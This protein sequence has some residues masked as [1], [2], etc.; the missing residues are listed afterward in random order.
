MAIDWSTV[1]IDD[2]PRDVEFWRQQSIEDRLIAVEK[3][4]EK[5]FGPIA[6]T[7]RVERVIQVFDLD[8]LNGHW[9]E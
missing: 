4:R 3:L 5:E 1:S 7:G 9:P 8:A 2:L 6:L